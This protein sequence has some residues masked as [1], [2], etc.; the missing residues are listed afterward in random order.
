[1]IAIVILV[2][3]VTIV[4]IVI[5]IIMT[6]FFI[7]LCMSAYNLIKF[8]YPLQLNILSKGQKCFPGIWFSLRSQDEPE[9]QS[10]TLNLVFDLTAHLRVDISILCLD[11]S[12][13]SYMMCWL[14]QPFMPCCSCRVIENGIGL[15]LL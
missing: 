13:P 10:Q 15:S 1:M 4:I 5:I 7:Q 9:P 14:W 12:K 8:R 3:M 11:M 6:L 2:T